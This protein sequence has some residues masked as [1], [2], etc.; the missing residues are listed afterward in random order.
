LASILNIQNVS[1]ILGGQTILES[2][3]LDLKERCFL[4]IIGPNGGG[5][6]M[7]LRLILGLIQ[8]TNG[9]IAVLGEQPGKTAGRVSYVP[10]FAVFSRDFPITVFDV[11]LQG[12]LTHKKLG[13]GYTSKDRDIAH[14]SLALVEIADLAGKHIRELSGGQLQRLLVARALASEP[15]LLLMDEPTA[16]LDPKVGTNL[17]AL[18]NNLSTKMSIILVSHDIGVISSY[19]KTVACLNK[20]MHYHD[21]CEI[22]ENT[23]AEVYGCPVEL[24][25]H[26]HAHRVFKEH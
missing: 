3:N 13:R 25:A 11:A 9:V 21:S 1:L 14:N 6:T 4:G 16:S 15:E 18:L 2:I 22:P 20:T 12:R 19:V 24:I 8:P 17:Y 5:K 7:L 26:G 23:L 10:Q